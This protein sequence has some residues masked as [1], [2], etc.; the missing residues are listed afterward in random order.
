MTHFTTV[1]G[2]KQHKMTYA[3]CSMKKKEKKESRLCHTVDMWVR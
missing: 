3:H 1:H 2:E